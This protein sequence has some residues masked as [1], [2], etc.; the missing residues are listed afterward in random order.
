MTHTRKKVRDKDKPAIVLK[1]GYFISFEGGEG[2]GKSTQINHL[3]KHLRKEGFDVM[4]T[5]EPGGTPGAESIRHVLLNA[6]TQN[7]EPMMEAILFA[8]AR[9]DH[10]NELIVPSLKAGKVVLCDRFIDSTRVYQGAA[11]N[12]PRGYISLLEKI[13]VDQIIPDLTFILDL[14]AKRGMARVHARQKGKHRTDRFEK[15]SMNVQENRRQAFLKIARM[16]PSRCFVI[17]ATRSIDTIADEI[18]DI[19]D[20]KISERNV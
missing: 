5:R 8:A 1:D 10:V 13:A 11:R 2:A 7:Y 14:P 16:E 19:S 17:D 20:R 9:T 4:V 15:A 3:A 18:A 6:S 12:I